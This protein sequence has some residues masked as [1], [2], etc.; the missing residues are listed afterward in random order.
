MCIHNTW[1]NHFSVRAFFI[2][3]DIT[4]TNRKKAPYRITNG[5]YPDRS[6]F[7]RSCRSVLDPV[8]NADFLQS[9]LSYVRILLLL[10]LFFLSL[11]LSLS[12]SLIVFYKFYFLKI[13]HDHFLYNS[14]FALQLI[15]SSVKITVLSKSASQQPY[16]SLSLMS[17]VMSSAVSLPNHTF[18][19]QA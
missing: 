11:S 13:L 19:G 15:H 8:C 18:T 3:L 12:L 10:L 9:V 4:N 5:T 6:I 1:I 7:P 14:C 16:S 17:R 2:Y